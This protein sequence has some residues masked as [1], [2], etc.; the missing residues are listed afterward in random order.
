MDE[1]YECA[2]EIK[3]DKKKKIN[4]SQ[5]FVIPLDMRLAQFWKLRRVS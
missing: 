2:N 4:P 5:K 3:K 1:D